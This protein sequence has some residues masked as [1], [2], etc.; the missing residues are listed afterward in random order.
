MF[1]AVY[2]DKASLLYD[3][4]YA[5]GSAFSHGKVLATADVLRRADPND[6]TVFTFHPQSNV[7]SLNNVLGEAVGHA[8]SVLDT[9]ATLFSSATSHSDLAS[10][11]RDILERLEPNRRK[12]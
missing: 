6:A 4:H 1:E 5:I 11:F 9:V 3:L 8:L 7:F 10:R 12:P 2:G